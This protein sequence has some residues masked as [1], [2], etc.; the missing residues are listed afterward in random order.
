MPFENPRNEFECHE[1]LAPERRG[2]FLRK[3][4][5]ESKTRIIIRMAEH[6]H[7]FAAYRSQLCQPVVHQTGADT[8]V[9]PV[10]MDRHRGQC[11]GLDRPALDLDTQAAEQD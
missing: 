9:L 3:S 8:L 1:C 4:S 7:C 11:S 6:N 5:R 10:R 2:K